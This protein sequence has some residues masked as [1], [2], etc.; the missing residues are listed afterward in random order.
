MIPSRDHSIC[1]AGTLDP[2]AT[3][4]RQKGKPQYPARREG[5]RDVED[6]VPYREPRKRVPLPRSRASEASA[7]RIARMGNISKLPRRNAAI[8]SNGVRRAPYIEPT[9]GMPLPPLRGSPTRSPSHS[10]TGRAFS[11]PP[12]TPCFG[13]DRFPKNSPQDC[14]SLANP[15]GEART[16]DRSG[17]RHL[18]PRSRASKASAKDRLAVPSARPYIE[19]AAS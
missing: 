11:R 14:F 18:P 16:K 8:I 5:A 19:I 12:C 7:S 4:K 15:V 2:C 13:Q 17:G 6:A 3:R 10:R 1:R 9:D